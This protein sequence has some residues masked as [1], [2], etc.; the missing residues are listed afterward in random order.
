MG[1]KV[2]IIRAPR[3]FMGTTVQ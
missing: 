1:N 3:V 2:K